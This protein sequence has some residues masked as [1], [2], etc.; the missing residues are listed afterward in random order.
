MPEILQLKD[1]FI[2]RLHVD[3][4]EPTGGARHIPHFDSGVSFDYDVLRKKDA[5]RSFALRL[6][7]RLE[8]KPAKSKAGYEIDSEIMG[9]FD[10]P[11]S[12]EEQQMQA[13]VRINGG[14]IL[15]GILRGQ[16]AAFT[17]SFP[18]GKLSLPAVYM[19]DIVAGVEKRKQAQQKKKRPVSREKA[20]PKSK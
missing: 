3:W 10:F 2:T 6:R 8:P 19:Q 18:G 5:L 14:T 1:F 15:Y 17:G 4:H 7:V 11:E 20:K 16:I 9:L 12:M 13:L